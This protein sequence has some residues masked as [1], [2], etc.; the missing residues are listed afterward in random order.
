MRNHDCATSRK[1]TGI[2]HCDLSRNDNEKA[3]YSARFR[4][5]ICAECGRVE[6]FGDPPGPVC[7]WLDDKL[8][9]PKPRVN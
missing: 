9:S 8:Q 2:F 7:E 4:M 3:L 1:V 6:L 5:V